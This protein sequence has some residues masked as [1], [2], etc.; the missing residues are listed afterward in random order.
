[1]SQ[2]RRVFGLVL[3]VIGRR[4]KLPVTANLSSNVWTKRHCV[5][6]M[7]PFTVHNQIREESYGLPLNNNTDD[8]HKLTEKVIQ[9]ASE[10]DVMAI[11]EMPEKV[12]KELQSLLDAG[13]PYEHVLKLSE[14]LWSLKSLTH[15]KGLI[16][17]LLK[18]GFLP[19]EVAELFTVCPSI[20]KLSVEELMSS[21]RQLQLAGF[22]IDAVLAIIKT[23][24]K[25]LEKDVQNISTRIADLK[26]LF[27]SL[28]TFNLIAT[29]PD[30]LFCDFSFIQDRFNYVFHEMGISQRQM[31]YSKLFTY[32]MEHIHVRHMFLVRAGFFRKIKNKDA[33]IHN[34]PSLDKIIDP[35]DEEFAKNF[36]GMTL[37]D[38]LAFKKLLL[39][40]NHI[41]EEL[42]NDQQNYS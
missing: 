17:E 20:Q 42:E 37:T 3:G 25:V 12:S 16:D 33:Q 23:D 38:Y 41:L 26:Q 10:K 27:K 30:L 29:N 31:M 6:M 2:G 22:S 36:G 5:R 9:K 40:E 4:M 35:S 21:P 8:I 39:R 32:P 28:D 7:V 11:C 24:P 1:M 14:T 18:F 19:S 34:N 15:V 13:M